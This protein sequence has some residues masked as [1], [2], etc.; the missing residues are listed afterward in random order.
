MN[1]KASFALAFSLHPATDKKAAFLIRPVLGIPHA[2]FFQIKKERRNFYLDFLQ[3]VCSDAELLQALVR[4]ECYFLGL[5]LLSEQVKTACFNQF[6]ISAK[7]AFSI[8]QKLHHY[9]RFIFKKNYLQFDPDTSVNFL[10]QVKKN[11]NASASVEGAVKIQEEKI[12]VAALQELFISDKAFCLY[13]DRLY[14]IFPHVH[15]RWLHKVY[16]FSWELQGRDWQDFEED[17]AV[18]PPAGSP[19]IL[20]DFP[21][22]SMEASSPSIL[23]ILEISDASGCFANLKLQYEGLGEI[24]FQSLVKKVQNVSRNMQE[25][26]QWEKDLCDAGYRKKKMGH[27]HY[28][29][30]PE[31]VYEVLQF[32]LE[33]GWTVRDSQKRKLRPVTEKKLLVSVQ[34]NSQWEIEGGIRF[35]EK[36]IS[37]AESVLQLKLGKKILSLDENEIGLVDA[38]LAAMPLEN[39]CVSAKESISFP[40]NALGEVCSWLEDVSAE[41]KNEKTQRIFEAFQNKESLPKIDVK[42]TF[43][44]TLRPY[45]ETGVGWLWL[46]YQNKL[47]GILA[48][49][50]GLG[51]TVQILAFCAAAKPK[52]P[53]L[54]VVPA[55]LVFQWKKEAEKFLPKIGVAVYAGANRDSQILSNPHI[56]VILTSYSILRQDFDSIFSAME[57][58]CIFLDEAQYIKN[59]ESRI[60]KYVCRLNAPARFSITG[61]PIENRSLDLWAQFHFIMPSLLGGKQKFLS[62][63]LDISNLRKKIAPFLLKRKKKEVAKEFPQKFIQ[64][65]W[66]EMEESQQALYQSWAAAIKKKLANAVE[67][68]GVGKNRLGILEGILRL[69]QICC[70]PSLAAA[71]Q[72]SYPSAKLEQLLWDVEEITARGQKVIIYSQF[73]AMLQIINGYLSAFSE[74]VLILDGSSKNR[75]MLV[76]QFQENE[77]KK[78]FL[79]SLK[80]GGVGLN[81][82]RADYVILFEPWWNAAVENQAMDRAHRLGREK[83]L[84][85][86]RYILASS[87]EENMEVLK[88][89]KQQIADQ[90][91]IDD[92]LSKVSIDELF[93]LLI[94]S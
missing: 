61:T 6:R 79:I 44:G 77:K 90:L 55:S 18:L 60:F 53:I 19:Q 80:A 58:S 34:D 20:W 42:K 4:E 36:Q 69:R 76:K 23:P 68:E 59:P 47:G 85:I 33:L 93:D 12:P 64:E 75:E 1:A 56:S 46:L 49:E 25:E 50:M 84:F 62:S 82:N 37:L 70:H 72:G 38:S 45:Q 52:L 21:K 57:F 26:M 91:F 92:E 3:E 5:S 71:D 35:G 10:Y 27:T 13:E 94:R 17:F 30:S 65:I 15:P 48:D 51:K 40:A 87:I 83:P 9:R 24:D 78:I 29:C 32:L 39:W 73:T 16:P 66:L 88:Q 8:L 74:N 54:I 22:E 31:K 63:S 14:P 43:Q 86:K 2:D 81:L 41:F 89:K 67:N 7:Q 28:F 11:G